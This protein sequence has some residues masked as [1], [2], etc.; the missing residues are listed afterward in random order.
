MIKKTLLFLL[1]LISSFST[2]KAQT[3]WGIKGSLVYNSNGELINEVGDIIDNN[4]NGEAGF[5][6]GFFARLN[7]GIVYIRPELVYTQTSSKYLVDP[8][9]GQTESFK[10]NSIDL[11]ILV[12]FRLIGPLN[13]FLGPAFKFIVKS[14]LKGLEYKSIEDD[15]TVGLNIGVSV[16]FGRIELG[17]KYDRGFTNNE[18]NFIDKNIIDTS[19]YTLDTRQQQILVGLSYRLSAKKK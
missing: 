1:I 11:P 18:A 10:M 3:G 16:K 12:G 19:S 7:L 13:F 6:A 8:E 15:I 4:G 2:I 5:N 9:T 17:V 14:D